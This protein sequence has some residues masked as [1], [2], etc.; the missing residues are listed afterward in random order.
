MLSSVH[1]IARYGMTGQVWS[2]RD[3]AYFVL[4]SALSVAFVIVS[5]SGNGSLKI[6]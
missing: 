6:I 2:S 1:D 3:V 5:E 4:F